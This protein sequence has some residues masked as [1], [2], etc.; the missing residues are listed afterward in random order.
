MKQREREKAHAKK[1]NIHCDIAIL[2]LEGEKPNSFEWLKQENKN[3]WR[4]VFI[5]YYYC[6]I[7]N[8]TL[9][10]LFQTISQ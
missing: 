3:Q 2:T 10:L 7:V 1:I 8:D 5:Y 9:I 4:F 6:H